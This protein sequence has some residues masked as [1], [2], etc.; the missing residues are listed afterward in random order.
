MFFQLRLQVVLND[1][2]NSL[3]L[4]IS[5]RVIDRREVFLYVELTAE[6]SAAE[7]RPIV[8]N[9]LVRYARSAYYYLPYEVL[10]LFT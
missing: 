5:L 6:F 3:D 7:L 2:I 4:A 10:D 8:R 9:D 1:F